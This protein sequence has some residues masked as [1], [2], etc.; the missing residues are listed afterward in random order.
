MPYTGTIASLPVVVLGDK[1]QEE[2]HNTFRTCEVD[3]FEAICETTVVARTC[4][5]MVEIR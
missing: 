1:F 3:C 2:V 4:E 5:S